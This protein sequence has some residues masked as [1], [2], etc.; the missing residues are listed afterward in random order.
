MKNDFSV[1][2]AQITKGIAVFLLL[3][4]HLFSNTLDW[5]GYEVRFFLFSTEQIV[6]MAFAAKICVAIFL[7][8]T[9]YGMTLKFKNEVK[10][11]CDFAKITLVK[12]VSLLMSFAFLVVLTHVLWLIFGKGANISYYGTGLVAIWRFLIDTLG[13]AYFYNSMSINVTWW[14]IGFL[15]VVLAV[16]PVM[17]KLKS[18]LGVMLLPLTLLMPGVMGCE[19]TSVM[20]YF[21][22]VAA[23]VLA[24]DGKWIERLA[25]V[26][27]QKWLCKALKW[28]VYL[29]IFLVSFLLRSC[30]NFNNVT[31]V[32]AALTM[33]VMVNEIIGKIPVLN[34]ILQLFG[35]YSLGIFTTHSLF[36]IYFFDGKIFSLK[37][38]ALILAV[39]ALVSLMVA[40]IVKKLEKIC[41]VEW[42]IKS[43]K[44]KIEES[45]D[46]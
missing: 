11:D 9:A 25:E 45:F 12:M 38:G 18:Y 39:L 40:I 1:K 7:F 14:Y 19:D 43:A 42:L 22:T 31:N 15:I 6:K 17:W 41:G 26:G 30:P 23:G 28:M 27:E 46:K 5:K 35:K 36:Y 20:H 24:A 3:F 2:D 37:Y 8:L 33:I 29:G 4:H 16:L 10:K 21:A 44:S 34:S 32:M 13:V